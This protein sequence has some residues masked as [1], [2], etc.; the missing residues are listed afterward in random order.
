[1]ADSLRRIGRFMIDRQLMEE[2]PDTVR[3]LWSGLIPLRVEQLY[4]KDAFECIAEGEPF[5]EIQEGMEAPTYCV[6]VTA[7]KGHGNNE[8]VGAIA[9]FISKDK[10]NG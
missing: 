3:L 4:H 10:S 1:M 9:K 6:E 7:V 2:W 8:V 5:A